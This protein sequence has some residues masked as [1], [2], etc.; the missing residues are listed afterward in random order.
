[1]SLQVRPLS[2]NDYTDILVQWWSDWGWG[3]PQRD[4]LPRN[5]EGGMIVFDGDEPVCAGYL[6][7]TNSKATWVDW[8]ISSKTYN[9]KPQRK[10]AL[11][12]LIATLTEWA[13]DLGYS[14]CYALIKHPS[15]IKVYEEMGYTQGDQY[16]QEMIIKL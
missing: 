14:Y 9:K 7:V 13:S 10:D 16:N 1:M 15:L 11:L 2:P 8:I 3:A 4:F 6:Y 12:L 5:G